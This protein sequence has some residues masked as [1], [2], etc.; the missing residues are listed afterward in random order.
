MRNRVTLALFVLTA[1]T[2][3]ALADTPDPQKV[4]A[5]E[6]VYENYCFT[7]HGEK[8]RSTGQ[9]FDLRKLKADERPRFESS[10]RNG[11]GQMPPW[12]GVL[13]NDEIDQLWN[14]IRANAEDR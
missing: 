2:F 14:F 7:C 9:S 1:L 6:G 4:A 13:S 3:P 8:L 5:G 11:K 12:E 10:V